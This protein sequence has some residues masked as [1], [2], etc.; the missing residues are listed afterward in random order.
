VTNHTIWIPLGLFVKLFLLERR[1]GMT[2]MQGHRTSRET[3]VFRRVIPQNLTGLYHDIVFGALGKKPHKGRYAILSVPFLPFVRMATEIVPSQGAMI[4][5]AGLSLPEVITSAGE[6]APFALR[7]PA[8]EAD[9]TLF[10][11]MSL[12][13]H[14]LALN[15]ATFFFFVAILA[16]DSR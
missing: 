16:A 7:S 4:G 10:K 1:N 6:R 3:T 13:Y 12:P 8:F 14:Y 9:G 2:E 5:F 15:Y 11:P